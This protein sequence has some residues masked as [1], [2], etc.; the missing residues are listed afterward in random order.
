MYTTNYVL[1]IKY[2]IDS[3]I[4]YLIRFNCGCQGSNETNAGKTYSF[5]CGKSKVGNNCKF[6]S[7]LRPRTHVPGKWN[8]GKKGKTQTENGFKPKMKSIVEYT[9]NTAD[10]I[11][12]KI[13]P[14]AYSKLVSLKKIN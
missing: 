12:K 5:G 2:N 13:Y 10:G 11:L 8:C 14:F 3:S 1:I 7:R 4:K 9:A 6:T